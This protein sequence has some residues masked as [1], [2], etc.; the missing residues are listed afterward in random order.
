MFGLRTLFGLT[1]IFF[2]EDG[3]ANNANVDGGKTGDD[4]KAGGGGGDDNKGD[5]KDNKPETHTIKVDGQDVALT[6][7]ELKE[8]AMHSSGADKRF[9]EAAAAT[10]AAEKDTR[11]GVL[12]K[13]ISESDNPSEADVR[14]LAGLW[15]IEPAE[16]LQNLKGD[17]SPQKGTKTTTPDFNKQ[18]QEVM[19]ASPAEVKAVLEFSQ[20]RHVNDARKE[21]REIS[22]KAVD[23]DEIIGKMIIGE[24]AKDVLAEVK[25]MVAEDVLQKI[26]NGKPFGAELVTASVQMV[27]SQLTKL[28]I[29]KKLNQQP[30]VLG[31]GPGA[32]LSS[33]IQADEPIKRVPSTKDDQE[34]N[35]IARYMQKA[36]Q[37]AKKMK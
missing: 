22:D 36:Y 10:K 7:E 16:F 6:L 17:D 13:T 28:G 12:V 25:N 1:R 9:Q 11:T 8:R 2:A 33:E 19:G 5:N 31:L 15:G 3:D 27:R 18:F 21:I 4:N 37:T 34:K 35:L 32:G 14:E 29:P 30:I 26:Q 23:K 24:D 20:Q